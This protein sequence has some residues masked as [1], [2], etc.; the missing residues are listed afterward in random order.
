LSWVVSTLLILIKGDILDRLVSG[1]IDIEVVII[2]IVYLMA[3]RNETGAGIFALGQGLLTD[4]FSGGIWGFHAM[5]YL[6]I[7]LFIRLLSRSFDLLSTFGQVTLIS[8]A[9]L[10]KGLLMVPMLYL[11][12]MHISISSS[13]FLLFILSALCSGLIASPVFY[14]LNS[15]GRFISSSREEI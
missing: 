11:F 10:V 4:I 6:I 2:I 7:F 12:S 14:L 13:D 8:M 3:Y 5:L 1:Y 15:L 9:F